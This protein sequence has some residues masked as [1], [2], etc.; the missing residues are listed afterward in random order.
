MDVRTR[1]HV[2]ITEWR[3]RHA[4]RPVQRSCEPDPWHPCVDRN[5]GDPAARLGRDD[6][7][8]CHLHRRAMNPLTTENAPRMSRGAFA[9]PLVGI[10]PTTYSLRVT[11]IGLLTGNYA[12]QKITF[13]QVR[14][15]L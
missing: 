5:T 13:M 9:E 6:R 8:D 11:H 1:D 3:S 2:W 7:G 10:E 4:P 15:C 14:A 12:G